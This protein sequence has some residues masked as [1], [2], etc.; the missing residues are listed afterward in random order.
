MDTT[1]DENEAELLIEPE[2]RFTEAAILAD[3]P[4]SLYPCD[5]CQGVF[6]R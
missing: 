6:E 1:L 4:W 2:H 5:S 3:E